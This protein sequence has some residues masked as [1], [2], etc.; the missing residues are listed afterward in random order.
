MTAAARRAQQGRVGIPASVLAD[1]EAAGSFC[2]VNA[3]AG[4][5]AHI[6]GA[7]LRQRRSSGGGAWQEPA[8]LPLPST[9]HTHAQI[10]C[11]LGLRAAERLWP[12][13]RRRMRLLALA[14]AA[15]MKECIAAT[16][17][18]GLRFP[19]AWLTASYGMGSTAAPAE[20]RP[21]L[22]PSAAVAIAHAVGV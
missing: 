16:S 2:G 4:G 1:G 21:H 11:S 5:Q 9:T 3:L 8:P 7:R 6:P 13:G 18:R 14:A 17:M 10:R 22:R 12:D 19:P 20:P 15:L